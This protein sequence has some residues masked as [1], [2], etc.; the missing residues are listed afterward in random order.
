MVI[1]STL[2]QELRGKIGADKVKDDEAV[3]VSYSFDSSVVPFTKPA[4]VVLP[5][6]R[7][8]VREVLT[9]ANQNKIPITVMSGG[10]NVGGMC[11]PQEG[12]IVLDLTR[13]DRILE[14]NTD[15]GYAVIEPG[16]TFDR[17]TA[18][19]NRNRFRCHIP[20]APGGATPLGNYLL[21]S[22]GSLSNRHLDSILSL[23]VVLPDGTI[24][25]TGSD[26][27][28][29]A[30][31][32]MR[33]GP[34]PDLTGLFCCAYGTLGVV[35]KAAIRVYPK[36][37]SARVNLVAFDNYEA[38][39]KFVKDIVNNNLAEHCIIWHWQ[40]VKSYDIILRTPEEPII[41]HEL[42]MD[43][44]RPP[45]G[46]PYN[47]VTTLM[48]GYEEMMTVAESLCAKIAHKY[49][50]KALSEEEME[51]ISPI[52]LHSWRQFY[53]DYHQP[54]VD[55]T[56]H[57]GLGRY[58]AWICL[59]EP[60]DVPEIE[61]LAL[62]ELCELGVAPLTYYSMPFDFGRSMFF[63]VFTFVDPLNEDLMKKVSDT[64]QKIYKVAMLRYGAIP[65]RYRR[66][67]TVLQ[68]MGGYRDLLEKVK[69]AL[70]PNNILN[71]NLIQ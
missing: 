38:S 52:A 56:K 45:K 69:K 34:F 14:I 41:P 9:T 66:G 62:Q 35:T 71:P 39:V 60:K 28:P 68:N 3:L 53:L 25:N 29:N 48:S 70:D 7:E 64:F 37:E 20:T 63:R 51:R 40:F 58:L 21:R 26:A 61:E 67:A 43:P 33:Y 59:A 2:C 1:I 8:D 47:I 6:T 19:L 57:F 17:L 31:P 12:G 18:A 54:R 5:E 15:S 4:L 42:R 50:G 30:G 13:M 10:V 24:V 55:E 49:G 16:V 27:F 23:E 22:S 44:R 65:F 46:L 11:V 32:H 36:N